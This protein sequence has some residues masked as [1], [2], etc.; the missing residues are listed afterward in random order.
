MTTQVKVRVLITWGT[1]ADS[2]ESC[3]SVDFVRAAVR[4]EEI[5]A[6]S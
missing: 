6:V 4:K 2:R 1:L 5:I 3:N